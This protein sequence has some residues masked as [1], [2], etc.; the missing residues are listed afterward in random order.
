MASTLADD[1]RERER[2][3][4]SD[5]EEEDD[6]ATSI[7]AVTARCRKCGRDVGE[8]YNSF[9]KVTNSYVS[10]PR[11]PQ[12][13]SALYNIACFVYALDEP[14]NPTNSRYALPA[15]AGSYRIDGVTKTEK[16]K[17][18]SER[19]ELAGCEVAPLDCRCRETLGLLCVRAPKTK[20]SYALPVVFLCNEAQKRECF[21]QLCNANS[22][23][24]RDRELFKLPKIELIS[25]NT[26]YVVDPIFEGERG[27]QQDTAM[28]SARETETEAGRSITPAVLPK[29]PPAKQL[30]QPADTPIVETPH[31]GGVA[32]PMQLDPLPKSQVEMKDNL[33]YP[34]N[35]REHVVPIASPINGHPPMNGS[36]H[37]GYPPVQMDA[38]DRLQA[39]VNHALVV[40]DER[41]RDI[42]HLE[43][44]VKHLDNSMRFVF[45]ELAA[46]KRELGARPPAPPAAPAVGIDDR[47]LEVLTQNLTQVATKANEVDSLKMSMELIKRRLS[48]VEEISQ[49][50]SPATVNGQFPPREPIVH[51]PPQTAVPSQHPGQPVQVLPRQSLPSPHQMVEHRVIPGP[52]GPMAVPIPPAPHPSDPS[53]RTVEPD[54]Q[55]SAGGWTTVNTSAKRGLPN[56]VEGRV[57]ISGTPL[58]S[59]KRPK[60]AP[61]EPRQTYDATP[62][63]SY[64]HE[65]EPLEAP[66]LRP[67]ST[68]SYPESVVSQSQPPYGSYQATNDAN[69]DDSWRP[70]SQRP[71]HGHPQS[72]SASPKR[73]GRGG[74]R[75]RPRKSAQHELDANMGTPEWERNEWTGSQISPDGYYHPITPS[76]RGGRGN[77]MRRGSGGAPPPAAIRPGTTMMIQPGDPYA[78]TKKSRTKPIRNADGVLIRKDGRP[79]MRSQSSA[80]NLRKVHARKE[81]ERMKESGGIGEHSGLGTSTLSRSVSAED[82]RDR[83]TQSQSPETPDAA[84]AQIQGDRNDEQSRHELVM[85]SMFPHGVDDHRKRV[86]GFPSSD[87]GHESPGGTIEVHRRQANDN[88]GTEMKV[89]ETQASPVDD[90]DGGAVKA[91][92]PDADKSGDAEM[93]DAESAVADTPATD[94]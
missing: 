46:V 89:D 48:R 1:A 70:E 12:L 16:I 68:E 77:V 43:N 76:T 42:S 34:P 22:P 64:E 36:Q 44:A 21:R 51:P 55:P 81:E 40:L 26:G 69:P 67:H 93:K 91:V 84:E 5:S 30:L 47:T 25:E 65:R 19:S 90:K 60:L 50:T 94:E 17:A 85:K 83:D 13:S 75:G 62:Q 74:G 52:H 92:A 58:G 8:F 72:A 88:A 78:H 4:V 39:Q 10:T 63:G 37:P 27:S 61:L 66:H 28:V 23:V 24:A 35:R 29:L 31:D 80:A 7:R 57:D 53:S 11:T 33:Q 86:Y 54:S 9:V 82:S 6:D 59:P 71:H 38:M 56:G 73:G 20:A 79:D 49:V 18:A 45:E 41:M 2:P 32:R 15:L 3:R 14:S 87:D